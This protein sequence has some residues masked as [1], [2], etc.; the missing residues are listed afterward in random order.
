MYSVKSPHSSLANLVDF[1]RDL[2]RNPRKVGQRAASKDLSLLWF[3]I[4]TPEAADVLLGNLPG[5]LTAEGIQIAEHIVQLGYT[6]RAER[7][8]GKLGDPELDAPVKMAIIQSLVTDSKRMI[9]QTRVCPTYATRF[10]GGG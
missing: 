1:A 9:E 7:L 2:E 10:R 3:E 6:D 5:V 4:G 8:L